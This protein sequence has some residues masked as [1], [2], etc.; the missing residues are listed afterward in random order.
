MKPIYVVLST[1]AGENPSPKYAN[2]LFYEK[3][4]ISLQALGY[5][6]IEEIYM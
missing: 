4:K 6:K 3:L 1:L 5:S 2:Q